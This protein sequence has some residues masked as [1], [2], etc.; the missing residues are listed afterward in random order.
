M[1]EQF[2]AERVPSVSERERDDRSN[3]RELHSHFGRISLLDVWLGEFRV[4]VH[5][6]SQDIETR[7][8]E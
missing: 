1:L 8:P 7:I 5:A 6:S 2:G 4:F 3:G